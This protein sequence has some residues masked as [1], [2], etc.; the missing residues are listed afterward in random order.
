LRTADFARLATTIAKRKS[1]IFPRSTSVRGKRKRKR[2]YKGETSFPFFCKTFIA[3]FVL[4][5][6]VS[7]VFVARR[8]QLIFLFRAVGIAG[9]G[10]GIGS[11]ILLA[12]VTPLTL[13]T[14]SCHSLRYAGAN[15]IV[16]PARRLGRRSTRLGIGSPLSMN[17]TCSWLGL[18]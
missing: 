5:D 16:F 18:A 3:I 12:N 10:I 8:V 1:G 15:S 17:A 13:Y 2:S 4:G 7:V 11:L 6:P 14:F 9:I